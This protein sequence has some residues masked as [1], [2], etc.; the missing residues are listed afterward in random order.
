MMEVMAKKKK[1]NPGKGQT[2]TTKIL[3]TRSY[4]HEAKK[5]KR[6]GLL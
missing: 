6:D 3:R 1:Q 5:I 4:T 2:T